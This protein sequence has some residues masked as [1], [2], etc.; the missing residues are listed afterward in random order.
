MKKMNSIC[1]ILSRVFCSCICC[2]KNENDYNFIKKMILVCKSID[3]VDNFINDHDYK[4]T[5][6]D[7]L[8]VS[9]LGGSIDF[10]LHFMTYKINIDDN[11]VS[12]IINLYRTITDDSIIKLLLA[13]RLYGYEFSSKDYTNMLM[14][15]HRYYIFDEIIF[16]DKYKN[17]FIIDE[18]FICEL[19]LIYNK[20]CVRE[21]HNYFNFLEKMTDFVIKTNISSNIIFLKKFCEKIRE[22]YLIS[23]KKINAVLTKMKYINK[24]LEKFNLIK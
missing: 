19:F 23:D 24:I 16:N 3:E 8:I 13:V 18:S 7:I 4:I 15:K 10:I 14:M 11:F 22:T 5:E 6:K 17:N 9:E 1:D 12:S 20:E 21:Y 2:Y